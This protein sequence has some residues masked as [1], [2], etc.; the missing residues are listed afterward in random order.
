MAGTERSADRTVAS[1]TLPKLKVEIYEGDRLKEVV[2]IDDPRQRW[3][4]TYNDARTGRTAVPAVPA[5]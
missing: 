4:R 3:C 5:A 2:E 1:K